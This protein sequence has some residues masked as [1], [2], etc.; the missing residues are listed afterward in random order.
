MPVHHKF[1]KVVDFIRT[2][3][4]DKDFIPLHEPLFIGNERKYVLDAIDSTFV[5]S[6]GAYVNKFEE[7]MASI[8]GSK[9]AVA[10]VNGTS[11]LHM[12]LLVAG[13][14]QG[15]EVLSQAFTF[16]ATANAISYTGASPVFIDID[17]ATMGMS[18][19]K[20]QNFLE[21]HVTLKE[22]Q[23]YNKSSKKRIAACVPMHSFGLP[24]EI[25][26]I[27]TLCKQWNIPL[28][29]DAAESLGSYYKGRH[30]GSFGQLGVFSFN[31]NKTLTSGGGG[32]IVTNDE[33]LAKLAK[34]LTT[35]AKMPHAWEFSHD[36]VGY[37]YRMPNLNAALAC[38][39]LEQLNSFVTNK[40]ELAGRYSNF[41]KGEEIPFIMEL[42][43]AKANYWLN[44]ILLS[45]RAERDEFLAYTNEHKVMTRPTWTLMNK[46]V[47]FTDCQ[48]DGLE[49]SQYIE[50][51]LVNIPSSVRNNA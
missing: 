30:T 47:M 18:A 26:R 28:I 46:L 12:A 35:Q 44:A 40:R 16:I 39:Q 11:A 7:M 38:A 23:P 37:N 51:R 3:F 9:F 8:T 25:E 33:N 42:P 2:Q 15:E 31:G 36:Y 20:L 13:V 32:A 5:S 1:Q 14:K 49:V 4:P 27:A 41:F 34:H 22:G 50:D 29:E 21:K 17:S 43:E 24:C 10:T 19:E 45:D 6:V 48:H